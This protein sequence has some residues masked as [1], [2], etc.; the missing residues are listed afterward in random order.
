MRSDIVPGGTFPDYELPD[1]TN[2]PRRLSDLQGDD[3]MILTWTS[4]T[5][6][7]P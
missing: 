4:G 1:H 5:I 3:P 7:G 2:V 6:C